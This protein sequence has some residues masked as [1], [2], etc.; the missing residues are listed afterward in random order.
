MKYNTFFPALGCDYVLSKHD[1]VMQNPLDIHNNLSEII[2]YICLKTV[3]FHQHVETTK[4]EK[5]S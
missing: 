3:F 1:R 4:K 2:C 5:K